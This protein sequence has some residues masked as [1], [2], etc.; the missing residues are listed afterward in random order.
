[1]NKKLIGQALASIR[2]AQGLLGLEPVNE[3]S[4]KLVNDAL[5]KSVSSLLAFVEE[6]EAGDA[7][8][9]AE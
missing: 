6:I 4:I 7:E 5:R 9:K 8:D 1:M 2:L 3:Y